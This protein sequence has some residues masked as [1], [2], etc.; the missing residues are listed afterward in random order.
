MVDVFYSHGSAYL[1]Y[2]GV[3]PSYAEWSELAHAIDDEIFTLAEAMLA[4]RRRED[5]ELRISLD[6]RCTMWEWHD[7]LAGQLPIGTRVEHGGWVGDLRPASTYETDS[8][9]TRIYANW[10]PIN[11]YNPAVPPPRWNIH[12]HLEPDTIVQARLPIPLDRGQLLNLID[13]EAQTARP[14][15]PTVPVRRNLGLS[16]RERDVA[17]L[18]RDPALSHTAIGNLLGISERTVGNTLGRVYQ[19]LGVAGRRQ[20]TTQLIQET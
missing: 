20:L 19:K 5:P 4:E 12:P 8:Y 13:A 14:P 10:T 1:E 3:D 6:D 17:L 16:K 7:A 18:A 9:P 2:R 11:H 15:D